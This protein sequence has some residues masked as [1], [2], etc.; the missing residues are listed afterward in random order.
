MDLVAGHVDFGMDGFVA[1]STERKARMRG[2][3]W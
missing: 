2:R 3:L 1:G